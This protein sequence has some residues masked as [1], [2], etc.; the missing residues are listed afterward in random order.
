MDF[1]GASMR[2]ATAGSGAEAPD[3]AASPQQPRPGTQRVDRGGVDRRR[4]CR[5]TGAPGHPT[6]QTA[7]ITSA[8]QRRRWRQRRFHERRRLDSGILVGV[9]GC[10]RRRLPHNGVELAEDRRDRP[11]A[12]GKVA[13]CGPRR[14]M[15]RPHRARGPGPR[16]VAPFLMVALKSPC[17]I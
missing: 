6:N 5:G 9:Q 11:P 12:R 16:Q 2:A 13:V 4:R 15:Q 7:A 3:L 17:R 10:D 8:L 14:I 1:S